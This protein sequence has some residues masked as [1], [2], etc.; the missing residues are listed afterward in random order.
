ME[1]ILRIDIARNFDVIKIKRRTNEIEVW[2]AWTHNELIQFIQFLGWFRYIVWDMEYGNNKTPF[3]HNKKT[4]CLL[5]KHFVSAVNAIEYKFLSLSL[6]ISHFL[7]LCFILRNEMIQSRNSQHLMKI[8]K[9]YRCK[10]IFHVNNEHKILWTPFQIRRKSHYEYMNLLLKLYQVSEHFLFF[11]GFESMTIFWMTLE[12]EEGKLYLVFSKQR[13]SQRLCQLNWLFSLWFNWINWKITT[14]A[15]TNFDLFQFSP[16]KNLY[17][18]NN[19]DSFPENTHNNTNDEG[20]NCDC[21][22]FLRLPNSTV[23]FR[24]CHSNFVF[25]SI[26]F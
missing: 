3:T 4:Y 19:Y 6:F 17:N 26:R 7:F 12:K 25:H 23:V 21:F 1:C 24:W 10:H 8:K 2:I 22:D 20:K 13:H 14:T 16:S 5:S 11:F 9:S 18:L 15:T